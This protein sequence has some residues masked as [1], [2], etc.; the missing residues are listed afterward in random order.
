MS[1]SPSLLKA[2]PRLPWHATGAADIAACSWGFAEA[3]L[4]FVI[5]DVA[6]TWTAAWS[7]R[8]ALRHLGLALL[9]AMVGGVLMYAWSSHDADGAQ[10]AVLAVPFVCPTLLH[11]A[12]DGLDSRGIWSMWRGAFTGIPY[13]VYA[14]LAPAHAGLAVFVL[15]TIPARAARFLVSWGVASVLGGVIRSRTSHARRWISVVFALVWIGT[16]ALYWPSVLRRCAVAASILTL[17]P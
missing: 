4:F 12:S 2:T 6:I 16:Y 13:K 1:E 10:R 3:T 17:A 14:V 7:P 5:P 8:R 9:G 15:A 11:D